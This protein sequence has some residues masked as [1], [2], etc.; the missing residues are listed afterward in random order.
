M[1]IKKIIREEL[2]AVLDSFYLLVS[3]DENFIYKRGHLG[4]YRWESVKNLTPK[5]IIYSGFKEYSEPEEIISRINKIPHLIPKH[6]DTK[7]VPKIVPVDFIIKKREET[8]PIFESNELDW[9]KNVDPLSGGKY[10][11]DSKV[12]CFGD[13]E[14]WCDVRITNEYITFYLA[15]D[16]FIDFWD[17]DGHWADDNWIMD[18]IFRHGT[19]YDGDDDWYEFDSDEFNYSYYRLTNNQVTRFNEILKSVGSDERVENFE[20]SMNGLLQEFKHPKIQAKFDYLISKY[21]DVLG[22]VIQKNRWLSVSWR[23][24]DISNKLGAEISIVSD[25]IKIKIPIEKAYQ[26][27]YSGEVNDLTQLLEELIKGFS[28]TNWYEWF[29]DEWDTSGGDEEIDSVFENFLDY[30]E[31]YL[32]SGDFEKWEK[33]LSDFKKLDIKGR[34]SYWYNYKQLERENPDDD[35]IWIIRFKD[36]YYK[37]DIELYKKQNNSYYGNQ[38]VIKKHTDVPVEEI[39]KYIKP[40]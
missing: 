11:D 39:P 37:A 18:P 34:G 35:T 7:V 15:E 3:E 32:E 12:I 36:D 6:Q 14:S 8:F 22:Y 13:K 33:V 27:Y 16:E 5:E 9:I 19:P 26:D 17:R 1:N 23:F 2:E 20:D 4:G 29:Y 28:Y 10:F 21:L 24:D 38:D 31:D 25:E 40:L 30:S